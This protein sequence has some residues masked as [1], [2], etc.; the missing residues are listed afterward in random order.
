MET[1]ANKCIKI[2]PEHQIIKFAIFISFYTASESHTRNTKQ[3]KYKKTK[4][5]TNDWQWKRNNAGIW[6][7]IKT[8]WR[9]FQ[10]TKT[11]R[12]TQPKPNQTNP[13]RG[14]QTNKQTN[15]QLVCRLVKSVEIRLIFIFIIIVTNRKYH[16][17]FS[18]FSS[19]G[20][21]PS[22]PNAL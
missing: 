15:S 1:Y 20:L 16:F 8:F 3:K 14:N 18:C 9:K 2:L 5:S 7:N 10:D 22:T 4:T 13:H 11:T 17:S 12:D 21:C 19:Y 6:L